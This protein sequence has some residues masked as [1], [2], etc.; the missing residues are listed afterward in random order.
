MVQVIFFALFICAVTSFYS[1]LA[2]T[3]NRRAQSS[4]SQ[5]VEVPY[6]LKKFSQAAGLVQ[7]CYCTPGSY[8]KGLQVGDSTLLWGIGDGNMEQRALIYHSKSLGIA[9]AYMGTNVSSLKSSSN[10]LLFLGEPP[11]ARYSE[12]FPEGV[13]LFHGFQQP[14]IQLV[15]RVYDAIKRFKKEY[16]ENR[17]TVIG[18]SQGA[19]IGLISSVDFENR[20]EDGI[21]RSYLFGL[22]RTGNPTFA[23]YVDQT[24]GHKLRWVVSG[25]D[26]VPA[27]PPRWFD[28]QHPSNYVWIYPANSTN[29]KLYPGQENVHGFPTVKQDYS[30]FDD[31]QGVYFH[32]QIGTEIGHCPALVGQD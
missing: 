7:Q 20:L 9:V 32:T 10:D 22:P 23:D 11:N 28:Y 16:N 14:Y 3:L 1:S 5:P 12:Y 13:K 4:T 18:H 31:H 30:N 27:V 17:V 25:D 6:D 26:W 2:A 15:D 29:W 19:A 8:H 24:I 21:Y